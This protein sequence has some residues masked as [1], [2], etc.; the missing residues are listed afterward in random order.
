MQIT[1][2]VLYTAN[3]ALDIYD[4]GTRLAPG[5]MLIHGG[6]WFEGDKSKDMELASTLCEA[7]Y[8]VWEPNYRLAPLSAYPSALHD[9]E[10]AMAFILNSNAAFQHSSIA[11]MGTSAGGHLALLFAFDKLLP[12]VS[13]SGP[14]DL[15]ALYNQSSP[16]VRAHA[17][18]ASTSMARQRQPD[19]GALPNQRGADDAKLLTAVLTEV[20]G[21]VS[22]LAEASPL[23][24]VPAHPAPVYLANS[25][26]EF[27]P[28]SQ[29]TA[30]QQALV[31][32]GGESTLHLVPGHAHAKG[33]TQQT[34]PGTLA[35]LT[36]VLA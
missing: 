29:A 5:V 32:A 1:K 22:K 4:P 10:T 3:L 8:F 27:I 35:F 2:D 6:G 28:V 36:R 13:W 31:I 18:A 34:L 15:E 17:M 19:Q 20:A 14:T 11:I 12:C 24:H 25:L 30:M 23:S 26:N 7:G 33:M 9:L 21:D 16:D